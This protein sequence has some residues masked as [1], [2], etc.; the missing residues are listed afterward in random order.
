MTEL[1][2]EVRL[3]ALRGDLPRSANNARDLAT[4]AQ[5]PCL[6]RRALAVVGANPDAAAERLGAPPVH[7]GQSPFAIQIGQ[8]YERA[9]T[10]DHHAGLIAGL[11][12]Q[13]GF[14]LEG[15]GLEDLDRDLP[16]P[17]PRVANF[18]AKR[19]EVARKRRERTDDVL[20]AILTGHPHAPAIVRHPRLELR[21][22]DTVRDVEPDLLVAWPGCPRPRLGEIKSYVDLRHRTDTG[23]LAAT[24][25]Q[26]GVYF[27]A[28]EQAVERLIG[29]GRLPSTALELLRGPWPRERGTK[30]R[31]IRALAVLRRPASMRPSIGVEDIGRDVELV[32]RGLAR[33]PST[34]VE[35]LAELPRGQESRLHDPATLAAVPVRYEPAWCLGHCPLAGA[36]RAEARQGNDPSCFG[37]TT[38]AVLAPAGDLATARALAR[39]EVAPGDPNDAGLAAFVERMRTLHER[40]DLARRGRRRGS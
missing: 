35:I 38:R 23:D 1:Y 31:A 13:L 20:V 26:L 39:G 32:Q 3:S 7:Y 25:Q 4:T 19:L 17:H 30:P 40:L 2:D 9:L 33:T 8:R 16:M 18:E 22:T 10:R 34:L 37:G 5:T 27:L 6:R 28:L 29:A 36:C 24:R 15:V 14:P 12:A 11:R 21:V